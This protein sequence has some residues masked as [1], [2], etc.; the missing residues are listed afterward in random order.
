MLE[1]K[2][3]NNGHHQWFLT[4]LLKINGTNHIR[5]NNWSMMKTI[6]WNAILINI[7]YYMLFKHIMLKEKTSTIESFLKF[8]LDVT[9]KFIWNFLFGTGSSK[10]VILKHTTLK[11]MMPFR[12]AALTHCFSAE[13]FFRFLEYFPELINIGFRLEDIFGNEGFGSSIGRFSS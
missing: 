3:K 7:V 8:S 12:D 6:L 11:F 10:N 13:S 9:W 4:S 5:R 1:N 2:L